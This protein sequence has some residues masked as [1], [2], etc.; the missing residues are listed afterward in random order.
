[1]SPSK[2][3]QANINLLLCEHILKAS[4]NTSFMQKSLILI[5]HTFILSSLAIFMHIKHAVLNIS[6]YRYYIF[7]KIR[8]TVFALKIE[9]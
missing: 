1:M 6:Q 2:T 3:I 5:L 9:K 8:V 7:L 4:I